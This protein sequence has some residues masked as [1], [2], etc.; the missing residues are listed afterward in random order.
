MVYPLAHRL[1][2]GS[3]TNIGFIAFWHLPDWCEVGSGR[4]DDGAVYCLVSD[5]TAS[6]KDTDFWTYLARSRLDRLM[7]T[8]L[9]WVDAPHLLPSTSSHIFLHPL[10]W[11]SDYSYLTYLPISTSLPQPLPLPLHPWIVWCAGELS[12]AAVLLVII[13]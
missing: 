11:N 5:Q 13:R 9:L 7:E 3:N 6:R 12:I 10:A 2:G 4:I 8:C 1:P